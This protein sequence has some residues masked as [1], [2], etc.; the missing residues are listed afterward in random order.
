MTR[1]LII[2]FSKW[3]IPDNLSIASVR[4][5]GANTYLMC[6]YPKLRNNSV[7]DWPCSRSS[8]AYALVTLMQARNHESE[9]TVDHLEGRADQILYFRCGVRYVDKQIFYRVRNILTSQCQTVWPR[10]NMVAI[11]ELSVPRACMLILSET[12]TR[13]W[14]GIFFV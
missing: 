12:I 7:S 5:Y 3:G 13:I 6:Y 11:F 9:V 8:N 14:I 4:S 10:K 2:L 1:M